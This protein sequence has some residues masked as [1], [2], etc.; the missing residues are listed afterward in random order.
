MTNFEKEAQSRSWGNQ[1]GE[2]FNVKDRFRSWVSE[3][4]ADATALVKEV[5]DEMRQA[6]KDHSPT[7][8]QAIHEARMAYKNRE[9]PK[10][11]YY[12]WQLL[13]ITDDIRLIVYRKSI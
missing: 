2:F 11:M 8:R 12:A 4:Y 10:V 6:A 1:I 3:E 7:M 13:D 9:Y 5:D